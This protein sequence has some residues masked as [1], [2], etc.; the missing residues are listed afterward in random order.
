MAV[1]A[2]SAM[3]SVR[4]TMESLLTVAPPRETPKEQRQREALSKSSLSTDE[5]PAGAASE[6][7]AARRAELPPSAAEVEV[8]GAARST[9]AHQRVRESGPDGLTREVETPW[10]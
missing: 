6:A 7:G 1:H 5:V 2:L 8:E 4:T 3:V 9:L 10:P